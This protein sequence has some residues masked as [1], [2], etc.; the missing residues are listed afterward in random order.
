MANCKN[1]ERD[2][3]EALRAGVSDQDTSGEFDPDCS[4]TA[5]PTTPFA[6]NG[7]PVRRTSYVRSQSLI[8]G[9]I[10]K[11]SVARS[12]SFTGIK[13]A[14]PPHRG[15]HMETL[16]AQLLLMK[17]TGVDQKKFVE[18]LEKLKDVY[19]SRS[20]EQQQHHQQHQQQDDHRRI[21]MRKSSTMRSSPLSSNQT[22]S[23][24]EDRPA[25]SS[26]IA[27]LQNKFA[28]L[29]RYKESI[30]GQ[31]I[32]V[33]PNHTFRSRHS[34]AQHTSTPVSSTPSSP[35]VGSEDSYYFDEGTAALLAWQQEMMSNSSCS[36][37]PNS[38]MSEGVLLNSPEAR[39]IHT[40]PLNPQ[41]ESMRTYR[42]S[43]LRAQ[44]ESTGHYMSPLHSQSESSWSASESPDV[45]E[46]MS[47]AHGDE[48]ANALLHYML[49]PPNVGRPPH[50]TLNAFQ[51]MSLRDRPPTSLGSAAPGSGSTTGTNEVSLEQLLAAGSESGSSANT[52]EVSL[53]KL[54]A[55]ER[56]EILM[57]KK[58]AAAAEMNNVGGETKLT[59]SIQQV[60]ARFPFNLAAK[61][62]S[63]KAKLQGAWGRSLSL[64]TPVVSP[65]SDH[66]SAD[67]S[68][69]ESDL[70]H[71]S[72]QTC[73]STESDVQWY[74]S[75][76]NDTYV[77]QA[78]DLSIDTSLHL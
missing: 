61:F 5:S 41:S 9:R 1:P 36:K 45:S 48:A 40:S 70:S 55:A 27:L 77:R 72:S 29:K 74:N 23:R 68:S 28:Q 46:T 69:W 7:S 52:E 21:T 44:S 56:M 6:F 22:F 53:E 10:Q 76:S 66:Y 42:R 2:R 39:G 57:A 37:A 16:Q 25:E 12:Q 26:T 64:N 3:K 13:G 30:Q 63:P 60:V 32:Q 20:E 18:V 49:Q 33:Y 73:R 15:H 35:R 78:Q 24:V 31:Q 34:S 8:N 38:P 43:T 51:N 59:S 11:P 17:A 65:A 4:P 54:L 75:S 47:P 50:S 67:I 14:K 19:L 58:A 62:S 71:E